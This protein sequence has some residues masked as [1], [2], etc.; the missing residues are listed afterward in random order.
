[1]V[2]RWVLVGGRRVEPIH[3]L[4]GPIMLTMM[5]PHFPTPSPLQLFS[6]S[7]TMP[8]HD[9]QGQRPQDSKDLLQGQDLQEAHVSILS[10]SKRSLFEIGP[11][12]GSDVSAGVAIRR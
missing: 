9:L 6:T 2:P 1:M 7:T 8:S 4:L 11:T 12:P 10:F 3:L 5:L